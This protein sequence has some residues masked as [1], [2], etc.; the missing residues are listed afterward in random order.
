MAWIVCVANVLHSNAALNSTMLNKTCPKCQKQFALADARMDEHWNTWSLK[1]AYCYCPHC[2][3]R[4]DDVHF[5]SVDFARHLTARN[6]VWVAFLL[7]S[8]FTGL[9]SGTLTYVGPLLVGSFGLWLA[10]SSQL[11]DHRI[12]GWV[13]VLI[14]AAALY[15][16][17]R[18][19]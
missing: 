1:P 8:T 6:L 19:A 10:R 9:V 7:L 15:A 5:D 14:S 17:N 18:A 3:E 12:I 11:R 4:L 16:F 13:W 2:G